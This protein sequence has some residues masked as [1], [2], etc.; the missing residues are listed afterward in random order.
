MDISLPT[1]LP[2]LASPGSTAMLLQNE[3]EIC[4]TAGSLMSQGYNIP[5]INYHLNAVVLCN[6]L[7]WAHESGSPADKPLNHAATQLKVSFLAILEYLI[8]DAAQ[9]S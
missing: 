8:A 1:N 4:E 5:A 2:S 6:E 7:L 3:V 9:L